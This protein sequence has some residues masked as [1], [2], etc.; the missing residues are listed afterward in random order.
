MSFKVLVIPEDPILDGHILKPL[1]ERLLGDAG[2]PNAKVKVLDKP[3][4]RGYGQA[5]RTIRDTLPRRYGFFDL[6]LFFPDADRAGV[7]AMNDLEADLD[8]QGI[9]LFCCR[10]QPEVEIYTCV[11]FRDD[12]PV[13]W[14]DARNHPRLK[15]DVFEPLLS[16]LEFQRRAP[17]GGRKSMIEQS[18]RNLPLLYQ[19][20]PETEQL[21]DRIAA[22]LGNP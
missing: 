9:R 16:R 3:R 22:R 13:T 17:G 21:R 12:L 8:A 4:L 18:L 19:L 14:E 11:A 2:K 6:W 20:C 15:E 5:V 1:A 7:E 10:A